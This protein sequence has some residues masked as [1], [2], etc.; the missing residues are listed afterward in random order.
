MRV[1]ALRE[2]SNTYGVATGD[3]A[4]TKKVGTEYDLPDSQAATL[5]D[6]GLVEEVKAKA[7]KAP[8]G[9]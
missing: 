2:H 1:K 9:K 8:A 4:P 7:E 3:N 5:I 6:L